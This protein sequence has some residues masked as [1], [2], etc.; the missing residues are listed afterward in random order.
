MI[1]GQPDWVIYIVGFLIWSVALY[2]FG[3]IHGM[4]HKEIVY[5]RERDAKR[6]TAHENLVK[7]GW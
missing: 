2:L 4:H 6:D 3:F 1:L 7:K 5:V